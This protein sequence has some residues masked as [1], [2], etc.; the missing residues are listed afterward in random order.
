MN[1]RIARW[2]AVAGC[3]GA[4]ALGSWAN[5]AEPVAPATRPVAAKPMRA[6][7]LLGVHVNNAAGE[8]IGSVDD[9]VIDPNTGRTVYVALGVGGVLGIGEKLFAVPFG[10]FK[11]HHEKDELTFVLDTTKEKLEASPGFDKNHWPDFADP[12]WTNQIDEYYRQ[13]GTPQT[14]PRTPAN[15][16][17]K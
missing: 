16:T 3:T 15:V 7:K 4:L 10:A 14:A 17:V 8:R 9:L 1:N 11:M 5:A 13:A 12:K 2:I 6:S